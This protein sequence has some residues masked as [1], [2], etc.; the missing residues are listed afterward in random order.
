MQT[1]ATDPAFLSRRRA[2]V[3]QRHDLVGIDFVDVEATSQS[4]YRLHVHFLGTSAGIDGLTGEH[5]DIEPGLPT[6]I[7]LLTRDVPDSGNATLTF[8]V[9]GVTSAMGRYTLRLDP[10]LDVAVA[11]FFD[12][13]DFRFDVDSPVARDRAVGPE[14]AQVAEEAPPIDYRARDYRGFRNLMLDRIAALVPDREE[15]HPADI[16]TVL[17]ES[18][19]HVADQLSYY[20]DA[21]ATEAYLGTARRRVSIRRHARLLGYFMHEGANARVW[22]AFQVSSGITGGVH[23]PR[24][25]PILTDVRPARPV[26][27]PGEYK[28]VLDSQ[29][30]L[31]FETMHP[32][33]LWPQANRMPLYT[34]GARELALE[35]GATSAH[36]LG[37]FADFLAPGD[38]LVLE[39]PGDDADPSPS[40]GPQSGR[41]HAIRLI[42]VEPASDP[43]GPNLD[44]TAPTELTRITWHADDALPFRLVVAAAGTGQGAFATGNIV[45]ADHGRTIAGE[46][47]PPP[48]GPDATWYRPRLERR[49]MTHAATYDHAR[50]RSLFEPASQTMVTDPRDARPSIQLGSDAHKG[51]DDQVWP[52]RRDLLDTGGDTRA[53]VVETESDR[54]SWLRFGDGIYGSKPPAH[55]LVA[56]YRIGSGLVGNIGARALT[57]VVSDIPGIEGV[58]NP[59]PALG[60]VEPETIPQVRIRAPRAHQNRLRTTTPDDYAAL[61]RQLPGVARA[62]ANASRGRPVPIAIR[63]ERTGRQPVDEAFCKKLLAHLEPARMLGHRLIIS[64]ARYLGIDLTITATT[65]PGHRAGPVRIALAEAFSTHDF[66]ALGAGRRGFFHPDRFDFDDQLPGQRPAPAGPRHTRG[67]RRGARGQAVAFR[68]GDRH[69]HSRPRHPA[70]ARPDHPA[71]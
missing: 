48:P 68:R 30:P 47:L 46:A 31:V 70:P 18:I 5:I 15:H 14:T 28:R 36:L 22:V 45:L 41:A 7:A 10:P 13:A 40:S 55:G 51:G 21:V 24:G 20:Q 16:L 3:R 56:R 43:L 2:I 67:R 42:A 29:S 63:V 32:A 25:T 62:M 54:V 58:T 1:I 59:L 57:H 9:N 11:P 39:Q 34:W 61:A 27:S 19:A 26:L 35:A 8:E 23:V 53:F 50:A 6:P 65:V 38:V 4:T 60:G 17:V 49:S 71:R 12:R 33:T 52:P 64:P 37:S 44:S 69:R 66:G